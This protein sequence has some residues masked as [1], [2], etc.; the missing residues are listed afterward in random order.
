MLST[1][2]SAI[3]KL[4][5]L[6]LKVRI[7]TVEISIKMLLKEKSCPLLQIKQISILKTLNLPSN[8]TFKRL[9]TLENFYLKILSNIS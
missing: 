4:F 3:K 5:C 7:K 2:M 6:K 8:I 1:M 9:K